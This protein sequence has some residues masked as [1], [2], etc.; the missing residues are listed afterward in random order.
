MRRIRRIRLAKQEGTFMS[1]LPNTSSS[2]FRSTDDPALLVAW[3]RFIDYDVASDIQKVEHTRTRLLIIRLTLLASILAVLIGYISNHPFSPNNYIDV[4]FA[5]IMQRIGI[6]DPVNAVTR[7]YELLTDIVRILL[8]AVP[9]A[10]TYILGFA[11]TFAPSLAWVSYRIGAELIRR[12]IYLYRMGAGDYLGKTPEEQQRLLLENVG[13]ADRRV[14]EIGAPDPYLEPS[15][16]NVEIA[17][18]IDEKKTLAEADNGFSAMSIDAYIEQH[19]QPQIEWYIKKSHNDYDKLRQW[20]KY[21]LLAS[22]TGA[23]LTGADVAFGPLVAVTTAIGTAI[24]M[25]TELRMYGHTYGLYHPTANKL[26][27][28][29]AEWSVMTDDTRHDATIISNFVKETEDIFQNERDQWMQQAIQ[30][31]N[32]FEQS[33]QRNVSQRT[34]Q[35]STPSDSTPASSSSAQTGQSSQGQTSPNGST[36]QNAANP[37]QSATQP[38]DPQSSQGQT[39]PNGST[40]QTAT[41]PTDPQSSQGQTSPNGS[42]TQNAATQPTNPTA[43]TTDSSTGAATDTAAASP[44]AHPDDPAVQAA[45]AVAAAGDPATPASDGKSD[46]S[47]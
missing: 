46:G 44:A 39:S 24:S 26:Q 12:D 34:T 36:T 2:K 35:T 16:G 4:F 33:L 32:S 47:G 28:K 29:L 22:A 5:W 13:L 20:R 6:V 15:K 41:Q 7:F 3:R 40:A 10:L 14:Q 42:A 17:T 25:Y 38:T 8:F 23:I 45:A 1:T 9:I 30:A 43:S 27:L 19:V 18:Y 21:V 31:S 11:S 37:S